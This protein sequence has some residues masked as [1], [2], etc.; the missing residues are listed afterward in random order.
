MPG[1]VETVVSLASTASTTVGGAL[2]WGLGFCCWERGG[3]SYE[4]ESR[5][6]R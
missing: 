4:G 3:E 6:H 1:E 5:E 2:D